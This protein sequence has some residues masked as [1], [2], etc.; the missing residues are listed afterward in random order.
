MALIKLNTRSIP[1]D[2]VTAVK[3]ADGVIGAIAAGD[4][5]QVVPFTSSAVTNITTANT[6]V[7]ITAANVTI[8]SKRLNSKFLYQF[9]ASAECDISANS[10]YLFSQ[11]T[12][13]GTRIAASQVNMTIGHDTYESGPQN[14]VLYTDSPTVAAGTSL[15]YG[16]NFRKSSAPSFQVNQQGL[17]GQDGGSIYSH[18]YIIEIAV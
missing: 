8:V 16:C 9:V 6:W 2:A 13:G 3:I 14:T 12:R 7:A 5:L 18:G 11:V 4:I 10:T 1:D 17:T 15:V